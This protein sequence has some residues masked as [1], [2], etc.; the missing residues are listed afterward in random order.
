MATPQ[1]N[2]ARFQ[3]IANRGLQDQ[4]D[5]QKRAVFDEAVNRGIIT[6]NPVPEQGALD[7]AIGTADLIGAAATGLAKEGVKGLSTVGGLINPFSTPQEAVEGAVALEESLPDF[8]LGE[9]GQALLQTLT[10]KFKDSPE[11]VQE[12]VEAASTLGPSIGESAFQATEGLPPNV[13]AGVAAAAGALPGALEAATVVKA[14]G[15]LRGVNVPAEVQKTTARALDVFRKQSKTKQRIAELIQSGSTDVETA[16]FKLK[17]SITTGLPR[18]QADVTATEAIRQGFDEGVIAAIKGAGPADKRA[19]LEM[20]NVMQRGK[21]NARFAAFNRPS[22][23][24]GESLMKRVRVIQGANREAG[25]NI[26]SVAQTLKGQPVDISSAVSGFSQRL[27]DLGVRLV[28]DGKG[29]FKPNFELSQLSPGDRGP[30]KEVIRQ[31][32]IRGRKPIDGLAAHKMKRIIDNNVTFGRSKTGISGDAESALKEFRA[33][34][35]DSLDTNFPAYN[36]VNEAY[37]ETIGALDALQDVAGRKMRL[38]GPNADKATGTLL[39]RVLSNAQSRIALL[40]SLEQIENTA[41]RFEGFV[42]KIDPKAIEGPRTSTLTDDILTQVLFVDELD[43]R[44][45]PVA[46]TSLQGQVQQG[47]E[48]AIG[49]T[50]SKAGLFQATVD[51][52][53]SALEKSRGL[54]DQ[55][56][57]KSINALLREQ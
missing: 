36:R 23:V 29:G 10:S 40:D 18:V 39:R 28:D 19:M 25:R 14:G 21:K 34:I 32:S 53:G 56:A 2:I 48:S 6:V 30:I 57:F 22:D 55:N 7:T 38:T 45:G 51:V 4:L 41:K 26:D 43:S 5:P 54:N 27:D 42:G 11:I 49:A 15:A 52:A 1:E 37:S 8:T 50:T 3:E 16:K 20:V 9:Q 13:R 33:L 44:F 17:D 35:D 12:I 31:M 46:R 47:L 24:V